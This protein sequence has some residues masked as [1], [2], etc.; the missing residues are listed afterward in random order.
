MSARDDASPET[1][2]IVEFAPQDFIA[3][4][5]MMNFGDVVE[6]LNTDYN[7]LLREVNRL[8]RAGSL[9]LSV[10]LKPVNKGGVTQMEVFPAVN[11]RMPKQ[12][13]G[14]DM[15]YVGDKGLQREHPRQ[16]EIEG[17]RAVDKDNRLPARTIENVEARTVRTA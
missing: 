1:G 4:L 11:V 14:A 10:S 2:E 15:L 12:D 5:R 17:L 8:G 7:A 6:R 13:M 16:K 9:T 3:A